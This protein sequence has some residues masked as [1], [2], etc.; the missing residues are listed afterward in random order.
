M[1]NLKATKSKLLDSDVRVIY[2][3]PATVASIHFIGNAPEINT[4]N[5][6]NQ[7]IEDTKLYKVKP[8]FRHYGFN[9]P[10]GILPDGSDH[11]YERWV[12]IPDDFEV[13]PPFVKKHFEGGLYCAH[14][15]FMGNFDEWFKLLDWVQNSLHYELD[16]KSEIPETECLE[17]HLN[18]INK[19]K[20]SPDDN[21]IQIDLL[22]PIKEKAR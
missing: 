16:F 18:S 15:I 8:D 6:L 10:N 17:E 13:H 1:A 19:Y 4:G 14:T 2:L 21:T 5:L 12:T 3:P 7:F 9:N 22:L 20:C 11:G